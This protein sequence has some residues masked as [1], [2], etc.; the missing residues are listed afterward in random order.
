M[1]RHVGA[2]QGKKKDCI[3]PAHLRIGT[4]RQDREEAVAFKKRKRG[5]RPDGTLQ[6]ATYPSSTTLRLSQKGKRQRTSNPSASSEDAKDAED[7][8]DEEEG[9]EVETEDDDQEEDGQGNALIDDE[10]IKRGKKG[11]TNKAK[12]Q[13]RRAK[14]PSEL[15]K[16]LRF[17]GSAFLDILEVSANNAVV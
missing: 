11:V 3:N 7:L 4:K 17:L 1:V 14:L 15:E 6:R 9:M 10:A 8:Y 13:M 5:G 12:P 2:C 16:N